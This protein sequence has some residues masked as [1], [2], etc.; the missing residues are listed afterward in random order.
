MI[1]NLQIYGVVF[2]A[3]FRQLATQKKLTQ[4][5]LNKGFFLKTFKTFAIF[6]RKKRKNSPD[7]NSESV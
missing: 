3:K 6:L 5:H 1:E 2:W 7:L 4:C